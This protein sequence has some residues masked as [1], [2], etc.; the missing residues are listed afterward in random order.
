MKT[1]ALCYLVLFLLVGLNSFSQEEY[2]VDP[3]MIR[4][5]QDNQKLPD[6]ALQEELRMNSTWQSFLAE[7]GSWWVQFD[8]VSMLPHRAFGEPIEVPGN[9]DEAKAW[10]FINSHL[11]GFKLPLHELS[12]HQ[13]PFDLF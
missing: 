6:L 2:Q 9:S 1:T 4:I 12:V 8:E 3:G 7:N 13:T 10:S 11:G 5:N